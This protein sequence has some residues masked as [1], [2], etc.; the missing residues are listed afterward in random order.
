MPKVS[1]LVDNLLVATI[2]LSLTFLTFLFFVV[3]PPTLPTNPSHSSS[4]T[5]PSPAILG[6]TTSACPDI[7]SIFKLFTTTYPDLHIQLETEEKILKTATLASCIE[8]TATTASIC[9]PDIEISSDCLQT[10]LRNSFDNSEHTE[11]IRNENFSK[12][13]QS[14][15]SDW[16]IDYKSSS[17]QLAA[18][19]KIHLNYENL[20]NTPQAQG[21]K[22]TMNVFTHT[23][24]TDG[25]FA[26][27]YIE[28]DG[29][30]QLLFL[31]ENGTYKTLRISGA[32]PE[33]NPVGIFRIG[34]KAQLAWSSTA[35]KWMPYWQ[36]FTYDK[37][38]KAWLGIH[39]L[40]YWFEGFTQTGTRKIFE[41]E[42]NIGTPKSTGCL[43]L[44][45]EDA[46]MVYNW[47]NS[48][49][50]IIIHD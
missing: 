32:F 16:E 42:S 47:T 9:Q 8:L 49:D 3:S 35:N 37:N 19:L 38:Q 6:T 29:S 34:E 30:R 20:L 15:I 48:G 50:Y 4:H 10:Q 13:V 23:P 7:R 31:W 41:P 21:I 39:A 24:N 25:T 26:Q 27:K 43:R 12:T 44:T 45:K 11:T 17:Q 1:S 28:V 2:P 46:K 22:F 36:A 14:R 40:V 33:Y 5:S 18:K